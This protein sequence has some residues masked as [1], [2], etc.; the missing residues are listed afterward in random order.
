MDLFL[1]LNMQNITTIQALCFFFCGAC[2]TV[3]DI[4]LS[5]YLLLTIFFVIIH[6]VV[7]FF[8]VFFSFFFP[9]KRAFVLF[10]S[11]WDSYRKQKKIYYCIFSKC[12]HRW[13]LEFNLVTEKKKRKFSWLHISHSTLSQNA[14]I[15]M[16]IKSE[17]KNINSCVNEINSGFYR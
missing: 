8:A 13:F 3:G 15:F 6:V 10:I 12:G 17:K 16:H 9:S 1:F 11:K 14:S 4:F 5:L 2:S 7:L